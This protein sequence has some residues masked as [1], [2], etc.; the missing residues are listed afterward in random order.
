MARR[1]IFSMLALA[2]AP[3]LGATSCGGGGEAGVDTDG[4]SVIVV[5]VGIDPGVPDLYQVHVHSHLGNGG[6]DRDLYFPPDRRTSPIPPNA[7]LGVLISPS[8]MDSVDLTLYGLDGGGKAVAKD[9]TQVQ[10]IL[11]GH[12]LDVTM[13]LA[14]CADPCN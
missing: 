14:A 9:M 6:T 4:Q 5:H 7:T 2:L 11:V 8:I 3:L 1:S 10:Q 13:S 12:Q